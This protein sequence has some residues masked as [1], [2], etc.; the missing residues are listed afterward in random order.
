FATT[1][2]L[3][4]DTMVSGTIWAY[5]PVSKDAPTHGPLP[6]PPQPKPIPPPPYVPPPVPS[7]IPPSKEE[8]RKELSFLWDVVA[9]T[10]NAVQPP[11]ICRDFGEGED[12]IA[13]GHRTDSSVIGVIATAW[14]EVVAARALIVEA[15]DLFDDAR[16]ASG[17]EQTRL[18]HEGN[19]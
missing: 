12:G 19:D 5:H 17:Q 9:T 18:V 3:K 6:P 7:P 16:H 14:G 1:R 2:T 10:R 8:Q 4:V 11:W 15:T 13:L